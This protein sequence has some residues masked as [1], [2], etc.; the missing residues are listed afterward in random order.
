MAHDWPSVGRDPG[1]LI[2]ARGP[3]AA[4]PEGAGQLLIRPEFVGSVGFA[5]AAEAGA[6]KA[7]RRGFWTP[8]PLGSARCGDNRAPWDW[9]GL[10]VR[11]A[12]A[13]ASTVWRRCPIRSVASARAERPGSHAATS[14][15]RR[16][17]GPG[18]R[19][20]RLQRAGQ[21]GAAFRVRVAAGG[22]RAEAETHG[23]VRGA[24]RGPAFTRLP[25]CAPAPPPRP[26][27]GF[28]CRSSAPWRRPLA[29]AARAP[30]AHRRRPSRWR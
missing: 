24:R 7:C 21:E 12:C 23:A 10:L 6:S 14:A 20:R 3:P 5:L 26:V 29:P 1:F 17:A 15:R 19:A 11:A 28:G 13:R 30:A 18:P 25:R 16:P 8:S 9:A 27:G 22:D 4:R 2:K